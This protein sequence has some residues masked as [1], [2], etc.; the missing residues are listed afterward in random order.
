MR[1]G[2][3]GKKLPGWRNSFLGFLTLQFLDNRNKE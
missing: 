3:A 1:L 2:I